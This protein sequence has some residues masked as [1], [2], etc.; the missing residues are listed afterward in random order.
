MGEDEYLFAAD[1]IGVVVDECN[2][3]L[4][5]WKRKWMQYE[6]T[7]EIEHAVV[8]NTRNVLQGYNG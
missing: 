4:E 8:V 6:S 5:Y 1:G 3:Q 7:Q 2:A